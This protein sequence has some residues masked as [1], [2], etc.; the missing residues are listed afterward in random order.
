M[1]RPPSESEISSAWAVPVRVSDAVVPLMVGMESP[2][3]ATAA[4]L[5]CKVLTVQRFPREWAA[6]GPG[7]DQG[8]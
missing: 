6:S 5:A 7:R 3:K 2:R 1:S 8:P 4:Q